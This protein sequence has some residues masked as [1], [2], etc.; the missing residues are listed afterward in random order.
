MAVAMCMKIEGTNGESKDSQ[1]KDW[2]DIES[3]FR[4]LLVLV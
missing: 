2:T 1:H 3:F 4:V